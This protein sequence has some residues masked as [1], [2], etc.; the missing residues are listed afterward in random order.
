VESINSL[1]D[2]VGQWKNFGSYI[3]VAGSPQQMTEILLQTLQT[4]TQLADVSVE[5]KDG[6][7]K[8]TLKKVSPVMTINADFGSSYPFAREFWQS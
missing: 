2:F 8:I 1:Y 4:V 6:Q 5:K 7:Q 3:G